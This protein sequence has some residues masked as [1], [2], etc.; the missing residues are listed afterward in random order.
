MN[1]KDFTKQA[2]VQISEAVAEANQEMSKNGAFVISSN[3][4]NTQ[5]MYAKDEDGNAHVSID[6]DFDIAVT[7]SNQ[8]ESKTGAL[9]VVSLF[10]LGAS[11]EEKVDHQEISRIKF[12]HP[13]A[14]PNE[15]NLT[16]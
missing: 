8:E 6:V 7:A 9:A 5:R 13:L 1:L 3:A 11:T 12:S 2:L 10:S 15:R 16:N 4:D 14:L